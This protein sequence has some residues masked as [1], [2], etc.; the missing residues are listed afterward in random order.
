M[1]ID[2]SPLPVAIGTRRKLFKKKQYLLC[3]GV[4]YGGRVLT[5]FKFLLKIL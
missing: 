5:V 3:A 4:F 2:T 1:A